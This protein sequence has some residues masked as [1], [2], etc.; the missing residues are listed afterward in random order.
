MSAPGRRDPKDRLGLSRTSGADPDVRLPRPHRLVWPRTVTSA[1]LS[2]N[3]VAS[4]VQVRRGKI[5]AAERQF[6]GRF[7]ASRSARGVLR[8]RA[9]A[10]AP[11]L[12]LPA[13]P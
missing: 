2:V 12:S 6:M 7:I 1:R 5:E 13:T 10:C 11:D 4:S 9:S 8:G 3:A